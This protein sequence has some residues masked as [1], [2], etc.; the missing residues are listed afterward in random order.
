MAG[1]LYYD[2]HVLDL[3]KKDDEIQQLTSKHE[4]LQLALNEQMKLLANKLASF[5]E[6]SLKTKK[7]IE[8]ECN[9][10]SNVE[11]CYRLEKS[12]CQEIVISSDDACPFC[13]SFPLCGV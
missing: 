10:E 6:D 3:Q 11:I 8:D 7:K 12:G 5:H 1:S 13:L 2:E 4:K 9:D